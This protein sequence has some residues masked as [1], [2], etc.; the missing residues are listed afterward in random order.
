MFHKF[1][2]SFLDH[3]KEKPTEVSF[4]VL[5]ADATQA[6]TFIITN[7]CYSV[8]VNPVEDETAYILC[9]PT[10]TF[11]CEEANPSSSSLQLKWEMDTSKAEE[12]MKDAQLKELVDFADTSLRERPSAESRGEILKLL[13]RASKSLTE[14]FDSKLPDDSKDRTEGIVINPFTIGIE[15]I[16]HFQ[17]FPKHLS[18]EKTSVIFSFRQKTGESTVQEQEVTTAFGADLTSPTRG[19]GL[20]Y[21]L[22]LEILWRPN[23]DMSTM[24]HRPEN[25]GQENAS[26]DIQR[27]ILYSSYTVTKVPVKGLNTAQSRLDRA[28]FRTCLEAVIEVEKA[29]RFS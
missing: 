10:A 20:S 25:E 14:W 24:Y 21:H 27:R 26:I 6:D 12:T 7:S 2:A 23:D 4:I 11:V 1:S 28:L 19:S 29:T 3:R 22:R 18:R 16:V 9:H 15:D 17:G 13:G 8:K 5:T